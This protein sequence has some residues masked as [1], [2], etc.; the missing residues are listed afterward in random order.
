MKYMGGKSLIAKLI[1]PIILKDREEGQWYVE[2]FVGG[3]NVIKLVGGNRVGY[4]ANPYTIQALKLI[5]DFPQCLPRNNGEFT[6]ADYHRVKNDKACFLHGY[7]G[8]SMSFGAKFWGGWSRDKSSNDYVLQAYTHSQKQSL[9]LQG[10]QLAMKDYKTL[11][12]KN[13]RCIIYCDPPYEGTK[14]YKVGIDHKEFWQWCRDKVSQ[15]HKVF[16]SEYKAPDDFVCVWEK[17][18]IT[19]LANN[20]A[21]N[22]EHVEKLFVHESQYKGEAVLLRE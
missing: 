9:L 6:E 3:G 16:I 18:Q 1:L 21:T 20:I 19:R 7:V 14:A 12:F 2:P 13:S 15:G 8:F 11:E 10:C 17:V 4:D 5:R 22:S